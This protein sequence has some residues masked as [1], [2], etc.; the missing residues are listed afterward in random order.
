MKIWVMLFTLAIFAGGT[1][2]GVA[3]D[4]TYLKPPSPRVENPRGHHREEL[5]VTHLVRQLGLSEA[6][7]RELDLLLGETQ[8]DVEAYQRAIRDR[9]ERSRERIMAMLS[10]EQKKKLEDLKAAEDKKHQEEEIER[11]LRFYTRLL[12]LDEAKTA[13]LR[14]I[15]VDVRAKRREFFKKDTPGEDYS[16]IRPFLQDLKE[17]QNRRFQEILTPEQYKRYLEFD[18][19]KH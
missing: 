2:L 13:A 3:V 8:R 5:S 16:K 15:L 11:S 12:E 6:Q 19:W 9:Y 7:D 1:C 17:E 18:S 14:A 4:R 10:E